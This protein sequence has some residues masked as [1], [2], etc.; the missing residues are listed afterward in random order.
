MPRAMR[1]RLAAECAHLRK[2]AG[3]LLAKVSSEIRSV[4]RNWPI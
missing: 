2:Q 3:R 4:A 1:A